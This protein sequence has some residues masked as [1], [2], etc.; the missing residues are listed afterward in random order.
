MA[1]AVYKDMLI[2]VLLE[3]LLQL[4]KFLMKKQHLTFLTL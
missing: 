4:L 1:C 2:V 3:S